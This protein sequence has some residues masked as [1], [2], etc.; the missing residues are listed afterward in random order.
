MKK[1]IYF[2]GVSMLLCLLGGCLS[3]PPLTDAEMDTVAEYAASLLLKYDKNYETPLYYMEELETRLTPT[4]TPTPKPLKPTAAP[5]PVAES[6]KPSGNNSGQD[7]KPEATPTPIPLYNQEETSRQLTEII[8][9]DNI[10]VAC[11]GWEARKSVQSEEYFS[12]MAKDGR[13]Y[14]VVS[15]LLENTTANDL[16][17]NASDKGLKYAIDVNTGTVSGVSISMLQNDMQYMEIPVP[18]GSTA[19]AALVFEVAEEDMQTIHLIV[20]DK[21]ENVVF[22]KLK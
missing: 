21:E 11:K 14:I 15:F 20:E 6:T 4:P 13:Q 5:T 1:R 7:A 10:S 22:V 17:F 18:A 9:V 19:E 2:I 3:V 8:A 12:L 16:V